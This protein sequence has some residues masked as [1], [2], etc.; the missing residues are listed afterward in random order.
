ME[1]DKLQ[2]DS[3]ADEPMAEQLKRKAAEDAAAA[4]AAADEERGR[5]KRSRKIPNPTAGTRS[6]PEAD[7]CGSAAVQR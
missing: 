2:D 7:P 6:K 4:S 3:S 5:G 1:L